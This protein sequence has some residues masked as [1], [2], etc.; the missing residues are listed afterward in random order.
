M[1][2]RHRGMAAAAARAAA[3]SPAGLSSLHPGDA[4]YLISEIRRSSACSYH[5]SVS[6]CFLPYISLDCFISPSLARLHVSE[7]ARG[8]SL[9]P[10]VSNDAT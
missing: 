1:E 10:R 9:V 8:H 3:S 7:E 6:P 2:T 5:T 4:R